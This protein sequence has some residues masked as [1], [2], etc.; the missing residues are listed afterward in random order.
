LAIAETALQ[1]IRALKLPADPAS[2]EVWYAYALRLQCAAEC[3]D[4]TALL[5]RQS[6]RVGQRR[7]PRPPHVLFGAP[8]RNAWKASA[9]SWTPRSSRP[10]SCWRL[11]STRPAI[12]KAKLVD[13][14]RKL[15]SPI[16]PRRPESGRR[17]THRP[18][19]AIRAREN[20]A[21]G[22]SLRL[23]RLQ[24]EDLDPKSGP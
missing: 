18:R 14:N 8:D 5:S 17:E 6:F 20:N 16:D 22:M 7:R 10:S 13:S 21:L 2:F 12:T 19:Q 9:T 24:I 3:A 1:Q 15:E 11:R 23:A 4:R